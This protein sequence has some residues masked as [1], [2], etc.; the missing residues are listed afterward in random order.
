MTSLCMTDRA[1]SLGNHVKLK[2]GFSQAGVVRAHNIK[3]LST[4]R[5][6]HPNF[7][8]IV[9]LVLSEAPLMY[10]I[11]AILLLKLPKKD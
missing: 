10:S 2:R 7:H 8:T 11:R 3:P 1:A 5:H 4:M 9:Y 6:C